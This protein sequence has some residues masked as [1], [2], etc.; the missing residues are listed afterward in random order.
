MIEPLH[1]HT[2]S[3]CLEAFDYLSVF[4]KDIAINRRDDSKSTITGDDGNIVAGK[5][6]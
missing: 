3:F 5:R 6:A 2:P 1:E 4:S